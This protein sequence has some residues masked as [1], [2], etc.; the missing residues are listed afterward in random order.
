MNNNGRAKGPWFSWKNKSSLA[1]YGLW[2]NKLPKRTRPA[3]RYEEVKIPGRAGSLLLTEGDDVYDSYVLDCTVIAPNDLNTQ[4]VLEWLRGS[5]DLFFSNEIEKA[6]DARIAAAVSFERVGNTLIQAKIP[7]LVKPFLH[8]VHPESDQITMTSSGTLHN[9]GDVASKPKIRVQK[10]GAASIT[11]GDRSMSFTHLPGDVTIDCD[12]E[13]ITT[14]A[15]TFSNSDYY[16]EGDYVNTSSYL[17]RISEDGLGS[18]VA[19]EQ[20]GAA[21]PDMEYIWQGAWSGEMLRI[22]TGE[23]T[24][25]LSGSP[26][27][28]ID[29]EWRWI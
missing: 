29:P 22:P 5:G 6:Y 27:L 7:F 12:T 15:R 9:P 17:Y 25:T 19:K 26:T 2:I 11:I 13:I 23:S 24:V 20:L 4:K 18:A 10:T 14:K 8:H 1:D 28:T 21:V 16:Y 3:E